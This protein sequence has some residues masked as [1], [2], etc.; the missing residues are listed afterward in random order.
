MSDKSEREQ[1]VGESN[2]KTEARSK[3]EIL[4]K[5]DSTMRDALEKIK[6]S[7]SNSRGIASSALARVAQLE[8][9]LKSFGK[10]PAC[11]YCG[12]E[13][14]GDACRIEG[15]RHVFCS[16]VCVADYE[17]DIDCS[18]YKEALQELCF[19]LRVL[20]ENSIGVDGLHKNGEVAPWDDITEGG[21][22]STWLSDYNRAVA[23]L[24][25]DKK[26]NV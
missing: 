6:A 18:K 2:S 22:F 11:H 10:F 21:R 16:P 1:A 26:P 23:L 5:I 12:N 15:S 3:L 8:R 17:G 24:A 9:D 7:V 14:D 4:E 19:D 13:F 20:M 25:K